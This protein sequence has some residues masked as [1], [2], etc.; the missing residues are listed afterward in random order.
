ML[1]AQRARVPSPPPHQQPR[2]TGGAARSTVLGPRHDELEDQYQT[3]MNE[4]AAHVR[5]MQQLAVKIGEELDKSNEQLAQ[6]DTDLDRTGHELRKQHG[7]VN[8][9]LQN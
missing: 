4:L 9:L 2:A 5:T 8:N 6:L 3:G 1:P 7:R